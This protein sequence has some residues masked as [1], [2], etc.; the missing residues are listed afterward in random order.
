M[1]GLIIENGVLKDG[2]A[3]EGVVEVPEGV[4]E[5]ARQAFYRNKN[6]TGL[7]LP[8]GVKKIGSYMVNGC[9]NLEY[10]VVPESVEELGEDAFLKKSESNVTFK[11]TVDAKYYLPEIRCKEGS[12]VDQAIKEIL[13]KD[14][15]APSG[16]HSDEH[17]VT[18]VYQ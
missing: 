17:I 4:T 16:S 18:V 7:I 9:A 10:I 2:K 3:C 6:L 15:L 11:H 1:E 5:I 13:S 12:Y 8:E 14:G